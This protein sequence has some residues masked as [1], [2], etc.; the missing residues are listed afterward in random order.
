[1]QKIY[2][3]AYQWKI[4][5]NFD[6]SKHA[7]EITFSRKILKPFYPDILFSNPVGSTLIHRNLSM[8]QESKLS[9]EEHIKSLLLKVNTTIGLI[10]KFQLHLLRNTKLIIC[11][12]AM[13]PHLYNGDLIFDTAYNEAFYKK[14]N[15]FNLL[16][17]YNATIAVTGNWYIIRES[18]SRTI[19]HY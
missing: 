6:A 19:S 14:L 16:N 18:L 1:M 13:T 10:C 15:P 4:K 9:L 8:I 3:W 2:E 17:L 7:Q 11:K 5:F 12:P